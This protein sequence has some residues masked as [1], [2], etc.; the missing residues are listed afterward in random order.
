MSFSVFT[1]IF[2]INFWENVSRET[3]YKRKTLFIFS[4]ELYRKK[5]KE[6]I[7]M[8]EVNSNIIFFVR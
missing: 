8:L 3:L 2:P 7:E 6:D 5:I 4:I 1:N